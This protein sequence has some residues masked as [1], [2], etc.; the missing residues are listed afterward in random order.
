MSNPK[1]LLVAVDSSESSRRAVAYVA[2]LVGGN[3]GVQVGLF[4]LVSTPRMLEWGG[5]EDGD[6]EDK[7]SEEREQAYLEMEQQSREV[8]EDVLRDLQNALAAKG[9]KA[10]TLPVEF[11]GLM[12]SK[13][14]AGDILRAAEQGNYGTVVAGK[15]SF[16]WLRHLFDHHVGEALVRNGKKI[17]VW[18]VE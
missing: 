2:D 11:E 6:V 18:V 14:I 17:A 10:D 16:S 9:V 4:H 7:V 3:P 15:H 12:N 8:G 13:H 1:K 5:S